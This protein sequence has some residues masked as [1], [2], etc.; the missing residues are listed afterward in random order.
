M[1][2]G[3]AGVAAEGESAGVAAA[4]HAFG[5]KGTSSVCYRFVPAHRY[6]HIETAG[7]NWADFFTEGLETRW[8]RFGQFLDD[9]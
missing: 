6:W 1:V 2:G 4:Q 7:C 8:Q 9:L 5:N 3:S